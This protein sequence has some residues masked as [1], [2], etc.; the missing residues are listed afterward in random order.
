MQ[1]P[2]RKD[3]AEASPALRMFVRSAPIFVAGTGLLLLAGALAANQNWLDRHFLPLF[4]YPR[5]KF[6]LEET[7]L[8]LGG[9]ALGIVLIVFVRPAVAR[10]VRRVPPYEVVATAFRI[11]LAAGLALV[12]S[13][14]LLG[15]TFTHAAAEG[16]IRGEEPQRQPDPLL[17]W[18]FVPARQG[19]AT[20]G[21]RDIRYVLD[22]HGYRM[23]DRAADA[24]R[25]TIL[26]TGESIMAGYGLSWDETI[27]AQ[28]GA[29]LKAQAVNMAVFGYASDQAYL[30]LKAELPRFRNPVAVVSL[31]TPALFLR[32][33]DDDRPHLDQSLGWHP[34]VHHLRL[35]S[36]FHFL[37]PYHSDAEIARGIKTTRAVL[38]AT[39][40]LARA[41]HALALVVDPQYGPEGPAERML[42]QKILDESGLSYVR[43]ELDPAWRLKG[44]LHPD[45]RATHAIAAAIARYLQSH[46]VAAP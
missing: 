42:R 33:L 31:F 25:P 26:F 40:G 44:D 20:L 23:R 3:Q 1:Y 27:P 11:L 21:G 43:V 18:R 7:L 45:R 24:D 29:M 28:A 37:V 38:S 36:L 14:F 32:N 5:E 12:A 9:G 19:Q 34:A 15:R 13:E 39:A 41:H 8:R 10:L 4:F 16:P 35:A 2:V 22:D 46:G 6:V 17:G 30:R